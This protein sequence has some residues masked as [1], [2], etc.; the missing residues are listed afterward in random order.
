MAGDREF[1]QL[2]PYVLLRT[3]GAGGMGRIDL[4]LRARPGKIAELCVLKRMHAEL[5]SLEQEARF[6]RE[7]NIALQ[8]SHGA[9]AQTVG[10]EEIGGEMLLLQEL[11][12]GVPSGARAG[13]PSCE[14]ER[15]RARI[16]SRAHGQGDDERTAL[17]RGR[18]GVRRGRPPRFPRCGRGA[19]AGAGT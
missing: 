19:V 11:I 2:G 4:A 1:R 7:A 18:A 3:S 16:R 10:I 17:R 8:L 12:H 14:R 13:A 6:R 15:G 9:I 5:R